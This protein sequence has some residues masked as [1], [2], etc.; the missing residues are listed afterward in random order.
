MYNPEPMLYLNHQHQV[1]EALCPEIDFSDETIQKIQV[2][3]NSEQTA[4]TKF[5]S[6]EFWKPT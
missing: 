5:I 3:F 6:R 4:V 1:F 2:P